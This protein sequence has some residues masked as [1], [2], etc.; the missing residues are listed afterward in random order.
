MRGV[1]AAQMLPQLLE[2]GLPPGSPQSQECLIPIITKPSL[3]LQAQLKVVSPVHEFL[4]S[5]H[6]PSI[7]HVCGS[8]DTDTSRY[9]HHAAGVLW[10]FTHL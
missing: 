6:P 1:P 5:H 3:I 8:V 10:Q 9:P 4:F 2:V 7:L